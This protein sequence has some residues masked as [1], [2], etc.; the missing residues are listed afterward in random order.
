[1]AGVAVVPR[2]EK[3]EIAQPDPEL[4]SMRASRRDVVLLRRLATYLGVRTSGEAL[5]RLMDEL[6]RD[7]LDKL[8]REEKKKDH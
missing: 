4:T 8:E 7:W 1:M 2:R 3:E 5:T 6:G